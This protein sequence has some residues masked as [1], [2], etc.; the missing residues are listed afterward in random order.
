MRNKSVLVSLDLLRSD[1]RALCG[2]L[3]PEEAEENYEIIDR[4]VAEIVAY[5]ESLEERAP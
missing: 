3:P 1:A 2:S 5:I 4:Q